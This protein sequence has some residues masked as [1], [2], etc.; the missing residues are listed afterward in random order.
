MSGSAAERG[1]EVAWLEWAVEARD[2]FL[3]YNYVNDPIMAPF[4]RDPR[5]REI[6][7]SLGLAGK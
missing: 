7:V 6:L 4:Q 5:G 2:R 1:S 3:I